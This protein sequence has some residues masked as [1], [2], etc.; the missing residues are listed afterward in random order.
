MYKPTDEEL[1]KF[2]EDYP[3]L[4]DPTHQPQIFLFYYKIWLWRNNKL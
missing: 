4:P 2:L 1:K 3:D